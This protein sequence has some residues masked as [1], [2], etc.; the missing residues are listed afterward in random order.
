MTVGRMSGTY[1]ALAV[2]I[3][4]HVVSD[5]PCEV[6][7]SG[8][9]IRFHTELPFRMERCSFWCAQRL[10]EYFHRIPNDSIPIVSS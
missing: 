9:S 5:H 6:S 7:E 3:T 1:G 8:D 4:V 10:F 2:V